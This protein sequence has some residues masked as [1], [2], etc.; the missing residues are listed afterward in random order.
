[1]KI[2]VLGGT[3]DPIHNGH[4]SI[5]GEA[6][7]RL[8][9]SKVLFVPAA[10]PWLKTDRVVTPVRHRLEMVR[11]AI[12]GYPY[13]ELSTLETDRSG[14]SY[15][16]DTI[17][18]LRQRLGADARIFFLLGWD[19]LA[20]L[21]EWKEPA[22]LVRLCRL[23]AIARPGLDRPDLEALEIFVPG[24]TQS[25]IWLDVAPI[26]ISAS[27]IRAKVSQRLPISSLVPDVVES[28]IAENNLYSGS[29]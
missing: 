14:P 25:V 7:A 4:L 13:F 8:N 23:V 21:P 1:M 6:R 22:R 5:A 27:A 3:F 17:A 24:I 12:A 10:Q 16:V 29:G 26:D 2:G 28:Y 18:T 15:T 9:L 19:S 11:R 20:E